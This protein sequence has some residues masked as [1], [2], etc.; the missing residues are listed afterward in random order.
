MVP[1]RWVGVVI[2]IVCFIVDGFSMLGGIKPTQ[3]VLMQLR[4]LNAGL[5]GDAA[6]SGSVGFG[7]NSDGTF[8]SLR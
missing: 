3:Q 1:G 4:H 7:M 2:G 8:L 5:L 6:A